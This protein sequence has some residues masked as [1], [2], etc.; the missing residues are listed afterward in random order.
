VER[1]ASRP[2]L[3]QLSPPAPFC[4]SRRAGTLHKLNLPVTLRDATRTT[5]QAPQTLLEQAQRSGPIVLR[6]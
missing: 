2:C 3:Y 5:H 4:T 6:I 1:A